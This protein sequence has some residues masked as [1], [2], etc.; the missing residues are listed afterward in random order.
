MNN[1]QGSI[2]TPYIPNNDFQA[3]VEDASQT[4][5]SQ[6]VRMAMEETPPPPL[7]TVKNDPEMPPPVKG[8]PPGEVSAALANLPSDQIQADMYAVMALFQKLAQEQ[9]NSAREVRNSEMQAQISTLQSA[10][11]EIRKAAADR[12]TGAII[13]GV[14]Q[15]A[16]GAMQVGGAAM[17]FSRTGTALDDFKAGGMTDVQLRGALDRAGAFSTAGDGAGKIA[18]GFGQMLNATM[19]QKAAGHDA[20]KAEL[21]AGAKAHEAQVQQA[22]DVMQQMQDVIRDIRDKLGSMEQA[23]LETTRGIARNI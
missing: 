2:S 12:L 13:S 20:H 7:D 18:G 4:Q 6:Q 23:R 21:E 11:Q 17:S 1:I 22:N 3:G 10:A 15:M 16:A 8:A 5:H 14:M 9:R 19:E